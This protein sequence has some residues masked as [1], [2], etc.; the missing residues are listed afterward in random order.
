MMVI[1]IGM[2]MPPPTPWTTR[3]KMSSP[4]FCEMPQSIDATVNVT[5]VMRYSR[6]VPQRSVAQPVSGITAPWASR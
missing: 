1:P 3:K 4:R 2:S 5:M 6:L